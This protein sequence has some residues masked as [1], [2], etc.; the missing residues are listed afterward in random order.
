MEASDWITAGIALAALIVA[1]MSWWSSRTSARASVTSAEAAVQSAKSSETSAG[2]AVRSADA[3]EKSA[4]AEHALLELE[5]QD[6]AEAELSQRLHIW[7]IKRRDPH[8]WTLRLNAAVAYGV[9]LDARGAPVTWR[10]YEGDGNTFFKGD[11]LLVMFNA[12]AVDDW[13]RKVIVRWHESE[14]PGSEALEKELVL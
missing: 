7:E 9:C 2:A 4:D 13:N 11:H 6:R 10:R 3:A 1:A 14:A 12:V 5:R 8:M